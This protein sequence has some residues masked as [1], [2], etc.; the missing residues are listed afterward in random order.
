MKNQNEG[1][2]S[3][4]ASNVA[5]SLVTTKANDNQPKLACLVTGVISGVVTPKEMEKFLIPLAGYF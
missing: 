5:T 3:S 4:N 2:P 1:E